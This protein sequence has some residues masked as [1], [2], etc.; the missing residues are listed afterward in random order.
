MRCDFQSAKYVEDPRGW[1]T[2]T[3]QDINKKLRQQI[4]ENDW[5]TLFNLEHHEK[6]VIEQHHAVIF[7][8]F[9]SVFVEDEQV[10]KR[11]Q[12]KEDLE[13]YHKDYPDEYFRHFLD[14]NSRTPKWWH[15]EH[16]KLLLEL[17]LRF[18]YSSSDFVTELSGTKKRYYQYRLRT[19]VATH[20]SKRAQPLNL[21][22]VSSAF[23]R[24]MSG[25][26]SSR[27]NLGRRATE[28]KFNE[29]VDVNESEEIGYVARC[30][31]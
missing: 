17:A 1:W 18:N 22:M 10:R 31:R 23:L 25:N 16:D 4:A 20:K 2:L 11:K 27:W 15:E 29:K 21:A 13:Q 19:K 30:G 8:E 5:K 3:I 6:L 24:Q 7:G 9:V 28:E 14:Q 12:T 26:S